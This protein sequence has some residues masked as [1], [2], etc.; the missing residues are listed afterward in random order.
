[1]I[2]R[3]RTTIVSVG[4]CEGSVSV[5]SWEQLKLVLRLELLGH[6]M[7]QNPMTAMQHRTR[8]LLL[9]A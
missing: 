3:I 1:M 7:T 9:L 6:V 8:Q 4:I 5:T 2:I